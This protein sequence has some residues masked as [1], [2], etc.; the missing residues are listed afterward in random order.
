MQ[1]MSS[2][3]VKAI[4]VSHHQG[5]IDWPK[6]RADGVLAT[7]IKASE[8]TTFVDNKFATNVNGATAAG[9]KT[10]FYHYAHPENND[11]KAEA[12]HFANTI[13]GFKATFPYVLDVEGDAAEVPS[14]QLTQW[15]VDWLNEVERLT[16]HPTMI[17]SGAY[18]AKSFLGQPLGQWP[19]WIAHYGVNKPM[20]ND[21]WD[22]WAVFQYSD[23]GT[24][25][26]IGGNVVDLNAMEK[27]FYDRYAVPPK[28]KPLSPEDT[29]KIVVNDQLAAYGRIVDGS[30]YMPL[31]QVG[32]AL[33]VPVHW[34]EATST[35]YV[36][37]SP[38][39]NYK[40]FD[41]HTYVPAR[42]TAE[43][44][45]ATVSWDNVNKKVYIYR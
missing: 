35:P 26:G 17:Y 30:A 6:V 3:N 15:C 40:L 44:L 43:Q 9:I 4:D 36:N 41:D 7:F 45:G 10:G 33:G 24:V 12:A 28:P 19:L 1:P 2:S 34:D 21:T 23:N 31:R 16:G 37:G 39:S 14:D 13:K 18:F 22:E 8:G 25:N 38:V 5:V 27:A 32:D 11:A 20:D 42:S 29:I